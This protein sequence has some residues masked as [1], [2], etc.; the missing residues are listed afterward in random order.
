MNAREL[1]KIPGIDGA[2]ESMARDVSSGCSD[3][4]VGGHPVGVSGVFLSGTIVGVC[5]FVAE[6]LQSMPWKLLLIL[7]VGTGGEEREGSGRA[8]S[9]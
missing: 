8:A 6:K 7:T 3:F 9:N 2:D 5:G 1:S 4:S